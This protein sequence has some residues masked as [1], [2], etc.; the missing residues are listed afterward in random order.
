[1]YIGESKDD[2]FD[3]MPVEFVCWHCGVKLIQDEDGNISCP[4]HGSQF[5][6]PAIQAALQRGVTQDNDEDTLTDEAF[7]NTLFGEE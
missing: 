3:T 6:P 1:M 7:L 2:E 4:T 5:L